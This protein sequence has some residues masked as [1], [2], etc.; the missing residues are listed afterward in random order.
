MRWYMLQTANGFEG[1]VERTIMMAVQAQRLHDQIE[2][3]TFARTRA[4]RA[5]NSGDCHTVLC[6]THRCSYRSQVFLPILEGE[7]SVR[8]SSVMPS[9]IFVRMR[10]NQELH[11]LISSL[12]YVVSFVGADRGGRTVSGQMQ[13]NRGFV[14]PLPMTDE[15]FQNI[16]QLTKQSVSSKD[17]AAEAGFAV[18][19][20]LQVL[21]GPFK[22]LQ[23]PVLAV[24]EDGETLTVALQVLHVSPP[25]LCLITFA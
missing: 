2:Q 19:E 21:E 22:G 11:F 20:V 14:R 25:P 18:D 8:E 17:G 4:R 5:E 3:A 15:Q 13:G 16:V 7:T 12:Q 24:G 23:G 9:Y 6:T 10:M 1:T